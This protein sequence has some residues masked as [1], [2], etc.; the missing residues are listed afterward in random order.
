[1]TTRLWVMRRGGRR[2]FRA[3]GTGPREAGAGLNRLRGSMN[4]IANEALDE[5][6]ERR[7]GIPSMLAGVGLLETAV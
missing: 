2:C 5:N 4:E 3:C 7:D 6:S 1:M